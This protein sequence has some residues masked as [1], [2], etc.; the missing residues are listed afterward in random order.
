MCMHLTHDHFFTW[1]M[2]FCTS[3]ETGSI[4]VPLDFCMV[5]G[6]AFVPEN[7][8]VCESYAYIFELKGSSKLMLLLQA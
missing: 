1:L 3:L 6:C 5:L 2:R 8:E 7:C 4:F